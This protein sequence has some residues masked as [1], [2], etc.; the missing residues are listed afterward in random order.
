MRRGVY[1]LSLGAFLCALLTKSAAIVIAPAVALLDRSDARDEVRRN[2]LRDSAPYLV[3]AALCAVVAI[4]SQAPE[5][6]GGRKVAFH[7]GSAVAT[8][9]TVLTVLPQYAGLL[10]YPA[11]LSALYSPVIRQSVDAAVVTSLLLW[12]ALAVLGEWLRRRSRPLFFWYA[13]VFLALLPV[14]QIVP[15]VTLMNDR[16]L[17]FPMLGIA[18]LAGAAASRVIDSGPAVRWPVVAVAV[19]ALCALGVTSRA[20]VAVWRND[21]A[22]WSDT[23]PKVPS[24]THGWYNLGRAYHDARQYDAALEAY[25][26]VLAL[27]PRHKDA[28]INSGAILLERNEPVAARP[29]LLRAVE[30]YPQYCDAWYDLGVSWA[31]TGDDARAVAAL[32]R[33]WRQCPHDEQV[34][35]VL[36]TTY[37]R[38][39]RHDLAALHRAGTSRRP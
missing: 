14:A 6:G 30:E 25:A 3:L 28:L 24:F 15:L 20:R 4:A 11:D 34:N 38:L 5:T 9:L 35:L 39:G 12:V 8:F 37:E 18:A 16:Y 32:D 33:A 1:A 10:V 29:F 21:I 13:F 17:Y 23:S 19:L 27:R 7:G 31:M 26:R 2:W 22:L 36:A